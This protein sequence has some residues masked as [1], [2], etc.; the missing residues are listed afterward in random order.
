ME[1]LLGTM[2]E[3]AEQHG[4]T[5]PQV[6][7]A[8]DIGKQTLPL[9]GVTKMQHAEEAVKA[10]ELRLTEYEMARLETAAREA[11]TDTKGSWEHPM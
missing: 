5:V 9:V 7:I 8:C 2:R 4:A 1:N 6:A 10:A 3:I 11:G